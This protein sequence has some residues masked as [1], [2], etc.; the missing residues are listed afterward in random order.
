MPDESIELAMVVSTLA[1][2]DEARS[3]ARRLV[4]ERL[5]ACGNV[6]PEITSVYRW[7]G[8][9]EEASEVL[10]VMK[11]RAVLVAALC[12]RVAQ[13]HPYEVPELLV[14]RPSQVAEAYG[15]WVLHETTEVNG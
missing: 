9:V 2:G 10:L 11:T 8:R 13:L 15:R 14:L 4:D 12:E 1:S 5:I 3:L 7:E 6:I